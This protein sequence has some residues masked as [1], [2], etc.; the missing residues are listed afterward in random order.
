MSDHVDM[1][2]AQEMEAIRSALKDSDWA[3]T[4]ESGQSVGEFIDEKNE[5]GGIDGFRRDY[6][7]S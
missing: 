7:L 1:V 2:D 4:E 3:E 5:P 6:D